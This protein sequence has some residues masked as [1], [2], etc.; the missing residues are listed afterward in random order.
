M[1]DR[2]PRIRLLVGGLAVTLLAAALLDRNSVL[3]APFQERASRIRE[4]HTERERQQLILHRQQERS[5]E[6]QRWTGLSLPFEESQAAAAYYPYLSAIARES[7]LEQVSIAPGRFEEAQADVQWLAMTLTAEASHAE[8]A[9]FLQLFERTDLL[10]RIARWDLQESGKGGLR[11]SLEVEAAC[12]RGRPDAMVPAVPSAASLPSTLLGRV[13]WFNVR[14]AASPLPASPV[15]PVAPIAPSPGA[16]PAG[17]GSPPPPTLM[18]VGT[19]LSEN[20]REAWFYE[21]QGGKSVVLVAGRDFEIDGQ[22]GMLLAVDRAAVTLGVNGQETR[23]TL[24][25]LFSLDGEV[26]LTSR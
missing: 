10:Q 11:G 9:R 14:N 3:L 1:S 8:W 24:G 4:L 16:E 22:R 19:W 6:L 23:I 7:G 17:D 20:R 2:S 15:V 13:D 21:M 18:L 25:G 5:R 26:R 12:L